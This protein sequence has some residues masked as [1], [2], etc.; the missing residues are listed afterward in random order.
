MPRVKLLVSAAG[1][2]VAWAPGD[3]VEF[4]DEEAAR[5]IDRGL[6][7][8][9]AKAVKPAPETPE[10]AVEA[11]ETPEAKAEQPVRRGPGRPRKS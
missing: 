9:V 8:A 4:S 6:A 7:E 10:K 5:W 2:D 11:P 1:P 3:V